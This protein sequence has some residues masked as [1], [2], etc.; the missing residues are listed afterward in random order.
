ME[1]KIELGETGWIPI[2]NGWFYN[3]LKEIYINPDL[4]DDK[5]EIEDSKED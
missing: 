3:P 2:K 4:Y 1:N 5:E